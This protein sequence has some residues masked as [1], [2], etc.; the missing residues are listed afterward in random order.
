MKINGILYSVVIFLIRL[1]RVLRPVFLVH[2]EELHTLLILLLWVLRVERPLPH[3]RIDVD[4]EIH[5]K[6]E[7]QKE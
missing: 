5:D 3:L 1:F 6:I 2:P 7:E 4:I